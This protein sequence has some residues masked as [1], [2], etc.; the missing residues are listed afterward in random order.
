MKQLKALKKPIPYF[1]KQQHFISV[2]KESKHDRLLLL[3]KEQSVL[4]LP[5]LCEFE[6]K[7]PN[8]YTFLL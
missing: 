7:G 8:I 4:Y 1:E 6:L 3:C 5:E 2:K